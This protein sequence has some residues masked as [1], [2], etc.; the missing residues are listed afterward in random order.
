VLVHAYRTAAVALDPVVAYVG[1]YRDGVRAR[2]SAPLVL[3]GADA[4]GSPDTFPLTFTLSL[5]GLE[6]G[7]Y[8]CQVTVLSPGSGKASFWRAPIVIVP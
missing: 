4:A 7:A 6:P 1:L 2:E 3:P 8:D 5:A